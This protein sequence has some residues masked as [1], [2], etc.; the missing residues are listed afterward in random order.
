MSRTALTN[1]E[2]LS[3]WHKAYVTMVRQNNLEISARQ[4]ALLLTVYLSPPPH[5]VRSLATELDIAKPVVTRA[6]DSLSQRGFIKRRRDE[7]DR[8]SVFVD[9]TAAGADFLST[10][11]DVIVEASSET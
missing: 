5:T 1:A 4:L 10:L 9:R 7:E 2:A 8:R 11:S 6:L 3:L